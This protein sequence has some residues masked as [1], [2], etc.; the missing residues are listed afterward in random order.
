MVIA[1]SPDEAFNRDSICMPLALMTID[2]YTR[3]C[4]L[5]WYLRAVIGDNNAVVC[6]SS[7]FRRLWLRTFFYAPCPNEGVEPAKLSIQLSSETCKNPYIMHLV[8]QMVF[9]SGILHGWESLAAPTIP[10]VKVRCDELSTDSRGFSNKEIRST[11]MKSDNT[12]TDCC[13]INIINP[14]PQFMMMWGSLIIHHVAELAW[15]SPDL[16][17]VLRAQTWEGTQK[18]HLQNLPVTSVLSTMHYLTEHAE[19]DVLSI[20]DFWMSSLFLFLLSSQRG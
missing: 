3:P 20:L 9:D 2:L 18:K 4:S 1:S 12:L 10:L 11:I 8:K 16:S 19:I 17:K 14:E 15:L 6:N 5:F 7:A 13:A